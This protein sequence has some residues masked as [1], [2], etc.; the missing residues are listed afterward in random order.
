MLGAHG[1]NAPKT[2]GVERDFN[3]VAELGAGFN[4]LCCSEADLDGGVLDLLNDM[5][6]HRNEE[7]GGNRIDFNDVVLPAVGIALDGDRDGILDLFDHVGDRNALFLFEQLE[8]LEK[9]AVDH[10]SSPLL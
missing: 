8:R 10:W 2:L 5:L 1:G 7:T 9:F 6:S 4:A 3:E